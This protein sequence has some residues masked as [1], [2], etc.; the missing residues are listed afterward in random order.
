M[1][2]VIGLVGGIG[3]GKTTVSEYLSSKYG[4]SQHRFSQILMDILDRLYLPHKREYLQKLGASLRAELGMDVIVNA[5]KKD[6]E[7]DP[8]NLIVIDGIRYDNEVEMLRSFENNI[9]IFINAPVRDR[10]VRAVTRKEKGE[11]S[12]TFAEFLES[13]MRETEQ[14]IEVIGRKADYI[15]D[16]T[17]TIEELQKK[18]DEI[19]KEKGIT[20]N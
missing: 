9:L 3:S 18:I 17:G 1:K 20:K 5:F 7:K 8:S 15:V 16:N 14:R 11:A 12:M 13:E 10:Y 6:L 2:L 4:A 19:M